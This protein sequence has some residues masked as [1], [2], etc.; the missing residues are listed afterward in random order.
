MRLPW[1]TYR[2][3]SS[4]ATSEGKTVS[5]VVRELLADYAHASPSVT[6]A[7]HAEIRRL[8]KLP[9]REREAYFL[10]SL[11]NIERLRHA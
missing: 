8:A 3:V 1:D 4:R 6:A 5:G 11:R 2:A 7:E 9:D 10:T